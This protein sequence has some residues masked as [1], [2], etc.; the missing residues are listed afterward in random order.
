MS[1]VRPV[2]A[3]AWIVVSFGASLPTVAEEPWSFSAALF[4]YFVP[5]DR[6]FVAPIVTADLES[7]HLEARLNYEAFE[8]GSVWV[9]RNFEGGESWTWEVTP[10]A[11]MVFGEVAGIAPGYKATLGWSMLEFYS[12]GEYVFDL[13][14]SADSFFYNWSELTISPVDGFRTGLVTQRTR[15]YASDREVQRGLL[16]GFSRGRFD[17]SAYLFFQDEGNPTGILAVAAGF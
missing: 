13:G 4:A 2:G 14:D 3:L 6:D 8:A 1:R 15:L 11:G 16:V 9:G 7:L 17:A 10:L 5:E 12:E